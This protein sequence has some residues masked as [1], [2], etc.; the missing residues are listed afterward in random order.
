MTRQSD[1]LES[2]LLIAG[3]T[4]HDSD[5]EWLNAIFREWSKSNHSYADRVANLRNGDGLNRG[6][7]LNSDTV[8]GD[9]GTSQV[10]GGSGMDWF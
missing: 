8:R 1:R 6:A 7:V 10:T 4:T 3:A 2:D 9:G 5:P